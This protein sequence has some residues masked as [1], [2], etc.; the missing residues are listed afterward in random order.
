ME[1]EGG[2]G[3]ESEKGARA[4]QDPVHK[5]VAQDILEKHD[6]ALDDWESDFLRNITAKQSL[7]KAQAESLKSI[8]GKLAGKTAKP[9]ALPSVTRG[10]PAYD[11]WIAYFRT[12]P[13]GAAF[14]ERQAS[15]T[16]P[17]EFPPSEAAA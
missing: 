7:T 9:Y 10:T 16:V 1:D 4:A 13:K 12:Q 11:A 6:E 17:T 3:E 8:Q 2:K 5:K 15:F 14:Y